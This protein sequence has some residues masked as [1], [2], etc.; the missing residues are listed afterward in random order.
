MRF[1][2]NKM[3]KINQLKTGAILSYVNILISCI[4][5]MFY[6][7]VMLSILGQ[8]E[9]GTYSL[10]NSVISYLSLLSFGMA[11]SVV[12]YVTKYKCKND[13][14]G[15]ER[16]AGLFVTIYCV[17]TGIVIIAGVI[18][19]FLSDSFFSNGLNTGE[20]L[21]LKQLMLIMTLSTAVSFP[22][23]TYSALVIA[24]ERYLFR[25]IIE[26]I[27]TV[28][29]P[30]FNLIVLYMGY[31]SIGMALASLCIQIITVPIYM[32]YC[33][34]ELNI[35]PKFKNMPIYLLKEIFSYT[36]FLFLSMIVDMLYWS[37]DKV[38]IGAMLGT[39]AVAIYN[40]G[41]TFT[42]MLQNMTTAI[43][44]VFVPRI[45]S[46]VEKKRPIEEMS[47]LLIRIGRLQYMIVALILSGYIVFGKVFIHFWAGDD[48]SQ[49]YTIALLTMIP[50][51][52]PL[53]Q[54]I[55]Y[56]VIVAQN[57]H[58]FRA[59]MYAVIAVL[60]VIMTILAIPQY[61]IIG[62]AA[63]TAIAFVIG[64]GIIMNAYYWRVIKLNIPLFWRNILKLSIVPVL[65]ILIFNYISKEIC[66]I[67]TLS[68]LVVGALCYTILYGI[69]MTFLMNDYEK[70]LFFGM[71]Q[72]FIKWR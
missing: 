64:N 15:V 33:K 13:H 50:L 42:S 3:K 57:K 6:T 41:G 67:N 19:T 45:M 46:M 11:N 34:K 38:L 60:N 18:L 14:E 1:L 23:V 24:Y 66:Q 21:K 16:V 71:I 58:R 65:L 5:P 40:I 22:S 12:R 72:K 25:R 68:G 27:G 26:I 9:Y 47:E 39:V 30:L 49:A 10:A 36:F 48:Y 20:L 55:A 17:I 4:I 52:I 8:N 62:A 51:A 53:I 28:L 44:S 2:K 35:I 29:P 59:I 56:N 69:G 54:N 32:I 63:C 7:P 43:S 31:G 37:T 70:N 61:G